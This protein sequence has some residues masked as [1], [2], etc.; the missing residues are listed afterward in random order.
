[1]ILAKSEQ[2]WKVLPYPFLAVTSTHAHGVYSKIVKILSFL[3]ASLL[4]MVILASFHFILQLLFVLEDQTR[5]P[6]P[7]LTSGETIFK[8]LKQYFI[9][10]R[11][12]LS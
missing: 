10:C 1:L 4:K 7:N 12:V 8:L 2:H 3:E 9:F 5:S 6:K 11:L